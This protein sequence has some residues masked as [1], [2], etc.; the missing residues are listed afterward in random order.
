MN[1]LYDHQVFD[2]QDI[3]GISRYF[4]E[5]LRH[6]PAAQLSLRYSDNIYLQEKCFA[7]YGIL[8]RN[9]VRNTFLPNLHFKGKRLLSRYYTKLFK[10]TNISLTLKKLKKANYDVFHPTYYDPYFLQYLNNKPFVL[11]V[12]DMI[13]ELFPQYFLALADKITVPNKK[14][15]ILEAAMIIATSENTKKDILR[16]FPGLAG[17]IKIIY[18]GSSFSPILLDE[19]KEDYILFTGSRGRYKNFDNFVMAAAPLLIKYDLRLI[20]TGSP[21]NEKEKA[22]LESLNISGR[23]ICK[24]ASEEDLIG[25]YSRAIAFVFPSLYEGF[26]IPI[27]EAFSASCPVVSSNTSCFPEIASDAAVYFDPY[28][29]DD[30]RNQIDSVLCSP[31]MQKDLVKKGKARQNQFSWKKCFEETTKVYQ[32]IC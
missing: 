17:K 25:L 22:L 11:T 13:H 15:L 3:G 21:F 7:D 20:C 32:S 23:V 10:K 24:F 18:H 1:V 14:R 6:N 5:L 4:V 16:F 12:H 30:M 29:I 19:K 27:L 28:S 2:F 8:P 26:G 31:S 9:H